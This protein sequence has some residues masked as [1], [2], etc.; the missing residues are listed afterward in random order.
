M[1]PAQIDREVRPW[2]L[3]SV[4]DGDTFVANVYLGFGVGLN[5]PVRIRDYFAPELR[6][7]GGVEA[8]QFL[9]ELI[10]NKTDDHTL[11]WSGRMSFARYVCDVW[12]NG[13]PLSYYTEV[14]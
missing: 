12:F 9:L 2:R 13:Q 14:L 7:P 3:V 1:L 10:Q 6:D 5:I 4:T 8:R 11:A